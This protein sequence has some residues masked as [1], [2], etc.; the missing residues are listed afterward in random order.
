MLRK[1]FCRPRPRRRLSAIMAVLIFLAGLLTYGINVNI[2]PALLSVM[3]YQCHS[4]S[5]KAVQNTVLELLE[6]E[7]QLFEKIY[8]SEYDSDGNINLIRADSTAINRMKLTL[9]QAVE[10]KLLNQESE[11]YRIPLGTLLGL[12]ILAEVGPSFSMQILQESY[13]V[14]DV[15][16]RLETTGVNQTEFTVLVDFSVTM[17]ATIGGDALPITTHH[18]IPVVQ[19]VIMGKVPQYYSNN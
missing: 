5:V 2:R 10:A 18:Q 17:S 9:C 12:S 1:E 11:T 13:V 15:T 16:T 8:R 19:M 7:P 4:L 3:E 6:E 14:A